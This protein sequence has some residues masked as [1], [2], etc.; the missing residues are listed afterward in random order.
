MSRSILY[1]GKKRTYFFDCGT[2]TKHDA[3]RRGT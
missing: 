1:R 3:R 2:C